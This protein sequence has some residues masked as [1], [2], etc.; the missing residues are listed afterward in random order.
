MAATLTDTAQQGDNNQI[1]SADELANGYIQS[2]TDATN[3]SNTLSGRAWIVDTG[4]PATM[5]NGL[6]P[7]PE[8]TN[9]YLQWKNKDGAVSP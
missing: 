2:Q 3:A 4:T 7:V 9:V 5:S 1:I 8:G 6:T